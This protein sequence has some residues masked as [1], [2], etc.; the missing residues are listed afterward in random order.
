[1]KAALAAFFIFLALSP[2]PGAAQSPAAVAKPDVKAGDRWVYRRTDRRAKPP[3]YLY[4]LQVSFIDSR[5]IHTVLARQGRARDS[6]ATWTPEW[7]G[8][9][10]VDDGVIELEQGLLRFPL[11]AGD[12]YSAAWEMRR[13]RAGA[14]LARH[15]R[16]VRVSGWEDIEVPA[17]KFRVL[18]VEANG[19]W[20]RL[21]TG[22]S[23]WARNTVWYSP[24][25]KRWVKSLYE[26]AQGIIGEEL[27][28]YVVQ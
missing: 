27:V 19:A 13:A 14:F 2:A 4:E 23:D 21:D 1:V 9:V 12:A 11:A 22:K 8:V 6:D 15:E 3:V 25:A 16:S 17:G 18:K 20:R 7:N 26:D 28:F 24:R 5:A 10:S